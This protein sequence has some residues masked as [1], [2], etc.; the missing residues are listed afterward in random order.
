VAAAEVAV[1]AAA[2]RK[3]RRLQA[4]LPQLAQAGRRQPLQ[5]RRPRSGSAI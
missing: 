2:E 3:Q 5:V 4:R 1:A